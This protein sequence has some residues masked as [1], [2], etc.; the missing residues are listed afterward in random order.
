MKPAQRRPTAFRLDDVS[1][2]AADY[3][4]GIGAPPVLT[5]EAD[6]F[7]ETAAVPAAIAA[8]P[9]AVR[10]TRLLVAGLGGLI[11]LAIGLAIDTLIRDLFARNDGLGWLAVGARRACRHRR[12]RH[13]GPRDRRPRSASGAITVL[14]A[15]AVE[16]VAND[17]RDRGAADRARADRPLRPPAGDGARPRRALLA[18]SARSSTAAT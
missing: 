11:A 9:R 10:W 16:A 1:T 6:P 14:H 2:I 12:A 5:P 18:M 3:V 13:R 8:A 7:A 17:D 4:P 15:G